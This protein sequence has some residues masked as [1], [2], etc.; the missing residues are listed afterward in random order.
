MNS[1]IKIQ[2][3]PDANLHFDIPVDP[4]GTEDEVV[5]RVRQ[6]LN[7]TPEEWW[8]WESVSAR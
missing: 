6:K 3:G 7:L 5:L 4:P 1:I 8:A 2:S